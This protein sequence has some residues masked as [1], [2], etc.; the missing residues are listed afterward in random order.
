MIEGAERFTDQHIQPI[1][2]ESRY[3]DGAASMKSPIA[4]KTA[5]TSR[6]P[7]SL[8]SKA[9]QLVNDYVQA[10]AVQC[11]L[12]D[13]QLTPVYPDPGQWTCYH[14][15][16]GNRS[17]CDKDHDLVVQEAYRLGNTFIHLC[18][19]NLVL[20]GIPLLHEGRIA[21]S[22]ISGYLLF[23]QNRAQLEAYKKSFPL[24]T[25]ENGLI[26]SKSVSLYSKNLFETFTSENLIDIDLFKQSEEKAY[27]QRA[28]GEK[29]IENKRLDSDDHQII[30][31]KQQ[32]LMN[33]IKSL[34][35]EGI[36][37]DLNDVLSEIFLEGVANINLLK[38]RMLELFVLMTRT[39]IESG[40]DFER[41][42]T[43]TTQYARQSE[44][45]EDIYSFSLW[46]KEVLNEFV[47][48]V[49]QSRNRRGPLQRALD[50]IGQNLD[51]RLTLAE[52]AAYVQMSESRFSQVF[53]QEIGVS[54]PEYVNSKKI[55][56]AKEWIATDEQSLTQ[57][58]SNLAFY[59][60]SY[61]TKT[62][63]RY[64]GITPKQYQKKIRER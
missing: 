62:F 10:T 50:Y 25:E 4:E 12:F 24:L 3:F 1:L 55:E 63:R 8:L 19:K 5:P 42:Y 56:K 37:D 21:G 33:S 40:G 44:K 9:K 54:F 32:N 52:V 61:F 18:H 64:V 49:T 23:E 27:I 31:L 34:N 6:I 28:I 14:Y 58:A 39:M 16:C 51:K 43:L 2:Q 38:F 13:D 45:L 41:F 30:Y 36:R 47:L 26:S 59:D 57:M 11:L 7:E 29:L 46:L 35:I 48:T 15:Y 60:Q 20:W 17:E 22:A 53:R